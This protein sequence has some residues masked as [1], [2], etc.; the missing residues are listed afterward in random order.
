MDSECN[1][2]FP[3]PYYPTLVP[4]YLTHLSTTSCHHSAHIICYPATSTPRSLVRLYPSLYPYIPTSSNRFTLPCIAPITPLS[5]ALLRRTPT[6][7]MPAPLRFGRTF[8]YLV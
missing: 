5:C 7:L 3:H 8:D 1:V 4:A 2:P 6:S